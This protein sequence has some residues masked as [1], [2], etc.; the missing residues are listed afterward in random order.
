MMKMEC[1][2]ITACGIFKYKESV[3]GLVAMEENVM[4]YQR[5]E[6]WKMKF[7]NVIGTGDKKI[8]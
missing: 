7:F 4:Q 5:V 8:K 2:R 3:A 6:M 1:L